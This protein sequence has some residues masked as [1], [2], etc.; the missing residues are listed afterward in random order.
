[1]VTAFREALDLP[2]CDE[3]S[4]FYESGGDSLTAFRITAH[5]Q[6][7]LDIEVPVALLFAYPTPA[8]LAAVVEADFTGA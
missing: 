8:E 3:H 7:A 1:M 6:E 5:L 4:D 2:E